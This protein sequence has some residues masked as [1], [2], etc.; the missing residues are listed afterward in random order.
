MF[1]IQ[2]TDFSGVR[3]YGPGGGGSINLVSYSRQYVYVLNTTVARNLR[4]VVLEDE[5][6]GKHKP[7]R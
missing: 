4:E 5:E 7:G 6:H 3:F 2:K 1:Q